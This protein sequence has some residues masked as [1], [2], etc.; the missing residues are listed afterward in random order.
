MRVAITMIHILAISL[1]DPTLLFQMTTRLITRSS[2]LLLF[3]SAL[4]LPIFFIVISSHPA[5]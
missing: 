5:N 3:L 4:I 2:P 1:M